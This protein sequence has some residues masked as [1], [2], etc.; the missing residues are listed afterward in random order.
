VV[1]T[2]DEF[3]PFYASVNRGTGY[4]SPQ[5]HMLAARP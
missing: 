3:L 4:M 2:V 5:V 1:E